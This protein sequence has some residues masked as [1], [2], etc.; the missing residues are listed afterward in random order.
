M[1]SFYGGKAGFSF[2]IVKSF[3]SVAEMVENF[4]KGPEYTA[5]HYDEHVLIN[6]ENK[7]DPDNGKVYRRG[8]DYTDDLGGAVYIGSIVGPAGRAPML[9]LTTI[10]KVKLK[11]QT[12]GFETRYSEGSYS[13][14]MS[15]IPG[16]DGDT[17]ND[18]ISWA[19][20]C[21][22]SENGE[23]SIAY[24]GF[25]IPY[26]V[27]EFT[28]QSVSPYYN[29]SDDTEDFINENLTERTDD[30]SH[31]FYEKWHFNIPKGIK[32]DTLKNF[33]VMKADATIQ[34]YEGQDDDESN[35]RE[36]LVYDYYHFDKEEG[37]EPVSLYL[38]DYNM[39]DNISFDEEGTIIIDYSHDD[40]DTYTKLMKWI[41]QVTLDSTNGHFTIIY[42]H[43]TDKDGNPTIYETD[44]A[45]VKNIT[46]AE[47]GN[48]TL[49]YTGGK[50]DELITNT[51]LRW[52]N[53][54]EMAAN[55]TVTVNYNDGTNQIFDKKIQ[56]IQNISLESNGTFTVVYNNGEPSYTTT[57][58]WVADIDIGD[59]GTIN[60]LYNNGNP[61]VYSK[62]LKYINKIYLGEDNKFHIIYNTG[63]DEAVDDIIKFI[64][65]VYIDEGDN[66]DYLFHVLYNTGEDVS[67]GTQPI[68]YIEET[69]IDEKDYH[70]LI[71][72][73]NP[74]IRKNLSEQGL[75]RIYNDK[76]GWL[77]L[78]SIKDDSGI[79]I[80]FNV[81]TVT[82][83]ETKNI[84]GA[85]EYL[86]TNYPNGLTNPLYKGKVVS[87]GGDGDDDSN[88]V[89]YA[90]DYNLNK[91]YYLGTF[92]NNT[93]WNMIAKEDD[94][95]I[96]ILKE[97]LT[98]G[99]V[100]FIV[101]DKND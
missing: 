48:I 4:Q 72:Y 18:E 71:Y 53:T 54:I 20:C 24:I 5:V 82:H 29:R 85:L 61:K 66:G 42:N 46:I 33:R 41:K 43:E 83:P 92:D 22:R 59:N 100:W 58:T 39:I 99:G 16:K 77:D 25:K 95:N 55:G 34:P 69:A 93:S 63:D 94:S 17:Y 31:P 68:N 76:D 79:L 50:A 57:L 49:H 15:I 74:N 91:W 10:E 89:F 30:K 98:I 62:M 11:Q 36:V 28:A 70:F 23:D 84:N 96:E 86:D 27:E 13:V 65:K 80:G 81:S 51:H 97:K 75:T 1:E 12:E 44:L 7:N 19:C 8:Y 37:G 2:I 52:I 6:T 47:N 3:S 101:E 67:L 87:V 14:P 56:W 9:E 45:W 88:K 38:G 64:N 73:S 60:I 21:V 40:T 26:L 35:Q 90:F 32:G 78:G